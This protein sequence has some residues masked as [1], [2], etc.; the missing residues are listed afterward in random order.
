MAGYEPPVIRDVDV[1]DELL[2]PSSL[3]IRG[4]VSLRRKR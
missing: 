3:P 2:L 4:A 1:L